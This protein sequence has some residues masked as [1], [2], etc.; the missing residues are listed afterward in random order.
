MRMFGY[1]C[2]HQN[3]KF[4]KRK[5]V[6]Q[7]KTEIMDRAKKR[8]FVNFARKEGKYFLI[9]SLNDLFA[10]GILLLLL[11]FFLLVLLLHLHECYW[12]SWECCNIYKLPTA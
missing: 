10:V 4:N 7:F 1:V 8:T 5:L 3:I 2:S 12:Q 11:R 9:K 6:L